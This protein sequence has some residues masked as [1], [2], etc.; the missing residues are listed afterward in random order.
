MCP[1][2]IIRNSQRLLILSPPFI[3]GGPEW[4]S[5]FS[6]INCLRITFSLFKP[7][8]ILLSFLFSFLFENVPDPSFPGRVFHCG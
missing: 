2:F 8:E 6:F 7:I 4:R 3:D 1:A 5:L